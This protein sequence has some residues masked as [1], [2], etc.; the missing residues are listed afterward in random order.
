[1]FTKKKD[2]VNDAKYM[3]FHFYWLCHHIAY[4][5][6]KKITKAYLG[7][8]VALLKEQEVAMGPFVLSYIYKRM[9]DLLILEDD[10]PSRMA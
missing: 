7:L 8:V 10:E 4:C 1:M 3:A 9:H 2:M 5:R 6:W